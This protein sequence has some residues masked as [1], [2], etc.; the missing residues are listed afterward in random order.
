[1]R[2]HAQTASETQ[3]RTGMELQPFNQSPSS[4]SVWRCDLNEITKIA[5]SSGVMMGVWVALL[6]SAS[7]L[8]ST[9]AEIVLRT[10]PLHN[11]VWVSQ[12]HSGLNLYLRNRDLFVLS[13][14]CVFAVT[15]HVTFFF[16]F[17]LKRLRD[18]ELSLLGTSVSTGAKVT[19]H[20]KF[21]HELVLRFRVNA[22]STA[23]VEESNGIDHGV[24]EVW[25]H[26]VLR[27]VTSES[28]SSATP[29]LSSTSLAHAAN[30]VGRALNTPPSM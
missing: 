2:E 16:S 4:I 30:G 12:P 15:L 29:L 11:Q 7:F 5:R 1:M 28:S 14:C 3:N 9:N 27:D 6:W 8:P 22:A 20:V 10:A 13:S 26:M 23:R 18:A 17:L 24:E 21:G 25:E 19:S